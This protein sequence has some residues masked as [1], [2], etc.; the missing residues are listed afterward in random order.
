MIFLF[1]K[2]KL[3]IDC[4]TDRPDVFN[5]SKID[6][7]HKFYPE[8]WKQTPKSYT[9][10]FYKMATL[11]KCRGIIDAYKYGAMVPLWSDLALNVKDKGYEWQFSDFK[12]KIKIHPSAEWGTYVDPNNYEHLKILSPWYIN[13]KSDTK[14]YWTIPFW[15]HAI[16]IP[17]HVVPGMLEF[18]YNHAV[19]INMMINLQKDFTHTIRAYTPMAHMIPVSDKE[20]VIKHHLISENELNN[21]FNNTTFTFTNRYQIHKNNMDKQESKCPF[22]FLRS[23]K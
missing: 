4:F 7:A 19:N 12:T 8:W 22:N 18:K 15:N 5:F 13:C 16:D 17:Y 11:K 14:F 6:Y 1:K 10:G 23:D 21:L 20:L 2:P 9:R 3:V